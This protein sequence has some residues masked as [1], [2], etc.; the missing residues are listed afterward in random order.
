[1]SECCT[2]QSEKLKYYLIKKNNKWS[3]I[4]LKDILQLDRHNF[5]KY[6]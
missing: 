6:F 2:S 5:K 3:I 4:F 1:M